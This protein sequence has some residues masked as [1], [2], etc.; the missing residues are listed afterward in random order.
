MT[1]GEIVAALPSLRALV[2]GDICLDRWCDYDPALADVSRETG[3]DRIAVT[4]V[5]CTPGGGGTVANNL[6]AF[7]LARVAVMGVAGADGHGV[8]LAQALEARGIDASG[9][10]HSSGVMTFTYTKLINA[11]TGVEDRPRV[12][13]IHPFPFSGTIEGQLVARLRQIHADFDLIFIADQAETASGGVVSA[14]LREEFARIGH[15]NPGKIIWADSRQRCEL[16]RHVNVKVNCAEAAEASLRAFGAAD[17]ERLR[18]HIGAPL[19]YVT[20]GADGVDVFG[21][22]RTLHIPTHRIE[23]PVDICGAGDSFS[24][25]AACALALGAD[26][27]E[28]AQFGNL[29]ASI[30][31]MKRGTGSASPAE[32]L[33]ARI[34]K[35]SIAPCGSANAL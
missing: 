15:E 5:V 13:Y 14:A 23:H 33:E 35:V 25:G 8:E 1:T 22:E 24:A 12:D 18:T 17:C 29:T 30:T 20:G 10:L 7:G 19:L 11:A 28:A 32:L 3:L 6:A 16:F 31:V 21:P 2:V 26:P 27:S 9:L 34:A 4:S